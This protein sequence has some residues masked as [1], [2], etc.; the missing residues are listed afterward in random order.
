RHLKS[1]H[2]KSC[3]CIRK[4]AAKVRGKQFRLPKSITGFNQYKRIMKNGANKRNLEFNLTD[5]ILLDLSKQKCYY[6]DNEPYRVVVPIKN[7]YRYNEELVEHSSYLCNGLDRLDNS[8]G[9]V[10]N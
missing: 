7:K 10:I 6:C 2:T 4:E 8:K 9:Y 3:G 1:Q 5:E